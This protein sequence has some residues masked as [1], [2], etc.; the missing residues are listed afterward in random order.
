MSAL[1]RGIGTQRETAHPGPEERPTRS[2]AHADSNLVQNCAFCGELK[3]RRSNRP[4]QNQGNAHAHLEAHFTDSHRARQTGL[5]APT[6]HGDQFQTAAATGC[7]QRCG[8]RTARPNSASVKIPR[9]VIGNLSAGAWSQS[10]FQEHENLGAKAAAAIT[11]S[12]L[13]ALFSSCSVVSD[14]R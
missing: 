9:K 8:S 6:I 5:V 1:S 11:A 13:M 7:T 14:L 4:I 2:A 10:S 12:E 3:Q